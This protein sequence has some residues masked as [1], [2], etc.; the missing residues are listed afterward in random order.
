MTLNHKS[1]SEQSDM[2]KEVVSTAGC[3]HWSCHAENVYHADNGIVEFSL[4]NTSKCAVHILGSP[5]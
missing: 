3:M 5:V 4:L 2:A 1:V